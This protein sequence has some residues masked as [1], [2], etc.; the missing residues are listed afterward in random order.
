MVAG[1]KAGGRD[2]VLGDGHEHT[3]IFKMDMNKDLLYSTWNSASM[4]C[5]SLDGRGV[6]G[7][8][9]TYGGM[10]ESLCCLSKHC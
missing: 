1:R 9:V 10:A 5:G 8:T 6:W 4:L 7:S 2:R 3:S